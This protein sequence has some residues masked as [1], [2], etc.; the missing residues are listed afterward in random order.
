MGLKTV[1]R[2]AIAVVALTL[3][4]VAVVVIQRRQVDTMARSNLAKAEQ[5]AERG[6]S[7]TAED[8]YLQ[9]IQVFPDDLD[10]KVKLAELL[11]K[12]S[13]APARGEQARGIYRDVLRR[14]PGRQDVRRV[15]TEMQATYEGGSPEDRD[16]AAREAGNNLAV[17]MTDE[18]DG[19]L[20]YLKG[21]TQETLKEDADAVKWYKLAVSHNAAEKFDAYQRIA[22][23]LRGSLDQPQQADEVIDEMVKSNPDDYRAYLGRGND[24]FSQFE[25]S[26]GKS[27]EDLKRIE[28][29]YQAAL[30]LAPKESS[31][32]IQLA[33]VAL[34]RRPADRAEAE[35]WLRAGLEADPDEFMLYRMLALVEE[36]GGKPKQAIETY[37]RGI[38]R[39]PDSAPLRIFLA[40]VLAPRGATAELLSQAE[41]LRRIGATFYPD[42][43]MAYYHFNMHDWPAA[44]AL[45]EKLQVENSS[46]G[47]R[48]AKVSDLLARCYGRLGD[49]ERERTALAS[50][51]RDNPRNLDARRRWVEDLVSQGDVEQAIGEYKK[52]IAE[53]P[54]AAE[55]KLA[56]ARL[57]IGRNLQLPAPRR[58]WKEVEGL[59]D[60]AAEAAPEAAQVAVARAQMLISQGKASEARALLEKAR[61]GK[62]GKDP[63]VWTALAELFLLQGDY[64]ES[65]KTLDDAQAKLGDGFELRMSRAR[66]IATR[67]DSEANAALVALTRD[68]NDLPAD[69]RPLVVDTIAGLLAARNDLAGAV[70]LWTGAGVLAPNDL[71]LRQKLFGVGAK[72]AEKANAERGKATEAETKA[73]LDEAAKI[74]EQA[75]AEIKR[76]DGADGN[77]ARFHEIAYKIL[78][79]KLSKDA[80]EQRARLQSEARTL[81]AELTSRRPDWS[82]IPLLNAQLE[83]MELDH[84][85]LARTRKPTPDEKP[86]LSRLADPY[87]QAIDMGRRNKEVVQLT[88]RLL[89]DSDRMVEAME[90]S[91]KYPDAEL[92]LFSGVDQDTALEIGRKMVESN[93]NDFTKRINLARILAKEKKP[94]QAEAGKAPD[95]AEEEKRLAERTKRL[96]EAEAVL[97]TG[98]NQ[99]RKD[100]SRWIVLVQFLVSAKQMDKAVKVAR[101]AEKAALADKLPLAM[102]Q[103]AT[104]IGQGYQAAGQES[105]KDKWYNEAKAW[106]QKAQAARPDEFALRRAT[107]DFLLQT[108]QFA[109][110]EG[111]LAPVFARP[112]GFNAD[113][114]AWAKRTRAYNF[115][116]LGEFQGNYQQALRALKF[117]AP[118]D[119]DAKQYK[120]PADLRILALVYEAQKI[121]AYR[122]RAVEVLEK[123]NA[124]RIA[125][126]EDLFLLAKLYSAGGE[127]DKA[128]A[129][130]KQLL[131]ESGSPDSALKLIRRLDFLTHYANDLI[132]HAPKGESQEAKDAQAVIDQLRAIGPDLFV[133]LALQAHLDKAMG[134]PVEAVAK[135]KEI[136]DRP[137]LNSGL[138]LQCAG[139]A[140]DVGELELA[141][142][143]FKLNAAASSRL[144]DRLAYAAF[145]GRQGRIKEAIDVCEP[146]WNAAPNPEP[147]VSTV[148]EA[149]FPAKAEPDA[150]QVERVSQWI[151]RGIKQNPK[152]AL[153][154]IALGNIRER[155]KRYAEAE[156]LYRL[157]IQQGG[158][159]VIPLNNLAW[160]M[161]LKGNKGTVPLDLIN[162]AIALRGP[163]PEFLDTRAIVYLTNGESKRAIEDL[164]DAVAISPTATKYF[165]L[166]QAYLE[167]SNK[168]AARQNLEKARTKGLV[169]GTLHPLELTAYQQV[170]SELD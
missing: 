60:K 9:H 105:Q 41:E 100:P 54:V 104:Q 66:A 88:A 77:N 18:S 63:V 170:I 165:H 16:A 80:P 62:A 157:V 3:A 44:K 43:Y 86:R 129:G 6:D 52:L 152:S 20:E 108:K 133:V 24:R 106:Y 138:A 81:I 91:N 89:E 156:E 75:L 123:L 128:R 10:A 150:A 58:D 140:E 61:D 26:P 144:Q 48:R 159:D 125:T 112:E 68:L 90:L 25:K 21:R 122:K 8:L 2:L 28:E 67:K 71:A 79:A 92:A 114:V 131:E 98:L 149:L 119:D 13:K 134:K 163:I 47:V 7:K 158:N 14:E 126:D 40:D 145:L 160:L 135:L 117:F 1:K 139:L 15:L 72:Q 12:G 23:L 124:D 121:P 65:L 37:H 35:R 56:L 103:C 17:L 42:Y 19:D 136:A 45:L 74:I 95:Q 59:L 78:Q 64:P 11:T 116:R 31:I 5:A 57:L 50:T 115:V 84:A 146:L 94:D 166:A 32:Y 51:L 161:A 83:E 38:E 154:L 39:L 96:D 76:I 99:D 53:H 102:A 46:D 151:E 97:R 153:F 69:R 34:R 70:R 162:R 148:I 141:Q 113:D 33:Q 73:A 22:R 29:D 167:A 109:D 36:T 127:W 110:V 49:P 27:P 143:L 82:A 93:P 137:G 147:L 55:F 120:S 101:E 107:V 111:Q 164:E 132:A 30:K 118:T 87:L 169:K 155:Q 142:R 130:Y 4:V 168:E 85:I